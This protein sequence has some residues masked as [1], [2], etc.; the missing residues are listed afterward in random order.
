[1]T[2]AAHKTAPSWRRVLKWCGLGL[3][4]L[5][6]LVVLLVGGLFAFLRTDAG[7]DRLSRVIEAAVSSERVT[8][9][10]GRL[11]GPFPE[12]LKAIDVKLSDAHGDL[13][14]LQSAEIAWRPLDLLEGRLEV[15]RLHLNGV[16][17]NR[18]PEGGE[19]EADAET[20]TGP[21]GL[22]ELPFD[23]VIRDVR[24]APLRLGAAV[25]GLPDKVALALG[26]EFTALRSQAYSVSLE[27]ERLDG[28]PTRLSADASFDGTR[29]WLRVAV[30]GSEP[31]GGLLASLLDLPARPA[32]RVDAHGEGPLEAWIGRLEAV[33]EDTASIALDV[34]LSGQAPLNIVVDGHAEGQRALPEAARPMLA[35]GIDIKMNADAG[36]ERIEV[37]SLE[38]VSAAGTLRG[39]AIFLPE[40]QRVEGSARLAL[41]AAETFSG[42]GL[43]V[44]YEEAAAD[45]RFAGVLPELKVPG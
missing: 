21:P 43:D 16:D 36:R 45:L 8:L 35:G 14:A 28:V 27:V 9:S 42:L 31:A 38:I 33:A 25:V 4:G 20:E 30:Q 12:R 37:H 24:I 22:P 10:I 41:G 1:M 5:L 6:A 34:R 18:L 26:A 3:A 29:D 7:L 32:I 15:T 23:V 17:V 13:I 11:D 2:E 40:D 39:A 44:T 19:E